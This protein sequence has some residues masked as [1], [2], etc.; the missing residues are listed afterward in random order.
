[1]IKL[2]RT[3]NE[4]QIEIKNGVKIPWN[5]T[6]VTNYLKKYVYKNRCCIYSQTNTQPAKSWSL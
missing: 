4:R 6:I 5:I 1:M 3:I 2:K